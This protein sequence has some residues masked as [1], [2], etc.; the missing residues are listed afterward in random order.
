MPRPDLTPYSDIAM[1]KLLFVASVVVTVIAV[2][3]SQ[4]FKL[5]APAL[6]VF[7]EVRPS[8]YRLNYDWHMMPLFPPVPVAIWLVESSTLSSPK[9]WILIDAGTDDSS[10]QEAILQGVKSKLSSAGG[11]LKAI[12]REFSRIFTRVTTTIFSVQGRT[13][14]YILCS[15]SRPQGPHRSTDGCFRHTQMSRLHAMKTKS[16]SYLAERST[17]TWRVT[18]GCTTWQEK[19][20]HQ[21]TLPPTRRYSPAMRPSSYKA[22]L[23]MYLHISHGYQKTSYSIMPFQ[24]TRQE[25]SR[26]ITN[27]PNLL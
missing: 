9:S 8:L 23:V 12:L 22:R 25:W 10:S 17:Q 26:F 24:G 13:P 14:G 16:L 15:D 19:H 7:E 4:W 2:G 11:R 20:C 1:V 18:I 27:L 3:Y 5:S 6:P 21:A